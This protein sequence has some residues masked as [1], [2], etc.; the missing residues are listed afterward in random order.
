MS[1]STSRTHAASRRRFLGTAAALTGLTLSGLPLTAPAA[2]SLEL[3]LETKINAFIKELR[4]RGSLV[5]DETTAW[6]V[7][8]LTLERKLVSINENTPY[9]SASMI[10][11]FV[12]LAYFLKV[13]ENNA[14]FKYEAQQ[15][16]IMADM[17][18]HSS[19][20]ATNYFINALSSRSGEPRE[21]ERILKKHAPDI[22]R[23]TL[24]VERIP[25]NGRTYENK[26]SARDYERFLHAL[27]HDRFPY[28]AELKELMQLPNRDRI[29]TGARQV[30]PET[31]ILDKTGTTARLCGNMGIVV[32]KGRNGGSYPYIFVAIIEKDSRTENYGDWSSSRGNI[33]R[34]VSNIVYMELKPVHELA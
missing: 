33:I 32:A 19:N 1:S 18:Q 10:K 23:E 30:A 26:A 6:S 15:R 5:P 27:W 24:I 34:E 12:A 13:R 7:Y 4:W 9:Q 28:S 21:V 8:D 22:F 20:T 31:R 25:A 16:Q 2:V 29:T 14:L 11:P 3:R 17:L